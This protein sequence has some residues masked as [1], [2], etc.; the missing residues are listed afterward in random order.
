MWRNYLKTALRSF[1][2]Q[3]VFAFIN[4]AGLSVGLACSI[5]ILLWVKDEIE[6]D[7]FHDEGDQIYRVQRHAYF[8]DGRI[9]TWQ[10]V[11][12]PLNEALLDFPEFSN[13]ILYSWQHSFVFSYEDKLFRESGNFAGKDFF[14]VFN[15]P[16]TIG[17]SNT[18]LDEIYSV[19]ISEE[20]ALKYF[21]ENWKEIVLGKSIHIDN[22]H[23]FEVTGVFGEIP[24]NSSLRFDY[25]LPI[26][27]YISR[28]DWV[29]HWGNSGLQMYAKLNKGS[30]LEAVNTKIKDLIRENHEP[31]NAD[32]F[33]QPFE[34]MRLYSEYKDGQLVGGR[35][36]YVQIFLWVA[37]LILVI[38][39]INFMNLATARS[40]RRALEIGIRKAVG[41]NK[42]QLISQFMGESIF[43]AL[44]SLVF[45]LIFVHALLPIFN[46]LTGKAMAI[47][48]ANPLYILS[49]LSVALFTGVLSG[50]YPALFLSSFKIVNV[51]KGTLKHSNS[52]VFLRKGLVVMQ[53]SLSIL[54]IIGT[55]TI[56]KQI[57]YIMSKNLGLDKENLVYLA[58]E[59]GISEKYE[60]FKHE[61]AQEPG[62]LQ[63]TTSSQNPLSVGNSTTDPEWD[64]K[65]PNSSILF[66]IINAH[67]DFL[68]AMKINLKEGRTF[69]PEFSTD[70]NNVMINQVAAKAMGMD[71]DKVIG[72]R[73][74]MWGHKGQI[75][76]LVEDFHI[77][78]LYSSIEPA[79]IRFDP[80][81][82]WM[83]FVRTEAGKTREA[84][85]SM[86]SVYKKFNPNYP[87]EYTFL[88]EE[89]AERYENETVMGTLANYFAIMAIFISCLGLFGLASFTAEQRT[90]EMGIRKV[91]GASV[92][93]L[94]MLLST[95]FT[96]LVLVAFA[97]SA[98]IAWYFMD[99]WLSDFSYRINLSWWIFALAGLGATIIAWLT[100]GYQSFK[101][102]SNNPVDS[103]RRE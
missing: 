100:I 75:I 22:R 10:S 1:K 58:L 82:T 99:G 81:N 32:V 70:T 98:P 56:H 59:G 51:L 24:Q 5:L 21:G 3:K 39:S 86:E 84:L 29:E 66:N 53:F 18:A 91:L 47:D 9:Y 19:V 101:A 85:A 65:D 8:T 52:A 57:N 78:S 74:D 89:Y 103:L 64:G 92:S 72:Q 61:L 67:Y 31:A 41:A 12:K 60:A 76:G 94:V 88:D 4:V 87:F 71:E 25:I 17:D 42:G 46:D 54:L 16:L 14:K 26:E 35:I 36:E 62:I 73:L 45:A 77:S 27:E 63:V 50:S 15:F 83:V 49:F 2:R 44:F 11:P 20:L 28:N 97:F 43:I 102:A 40:L 69:S 96:R 23:D 95:D 55:L 7:K 68:D 90:K 33:L 37:F 38:A 80:E 6:F 34:D 30:D 48:Y 13:T 93:Q 79:I